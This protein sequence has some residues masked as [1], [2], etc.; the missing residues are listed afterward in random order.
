[1]KERRVLDENNKLK[2]VI[3]THIFDEDSYHV[4]EQIFDD[5]YF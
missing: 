1:M 2:I 3:F 5:N 4:G